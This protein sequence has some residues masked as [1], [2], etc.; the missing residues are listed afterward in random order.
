MKFS[1][2]AIAAAALTTSANAF[3]AAPARGF[4]VRNVSIDMQNRGISVAL[5]D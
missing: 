3:T 4:A 5:V 1:M 2:L